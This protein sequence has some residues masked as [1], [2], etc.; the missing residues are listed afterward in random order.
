MSNS[1]HPV[2]DPLAIFG[3]TFDPVHY[4]H[5]RCAEE[6]RSQLGL[7]TVY[8]L[9]SGTPPHR[10]VPQ[11]TTQQRLEMLQLALGEFPALGIDGRETH[12]SG[13]SYMID[14]LM[15]LKA[16]Y[17]E[18]PI[19]LLLG[20]DV[21]NDLHTW[22]EWERLFDFAHIVVLTRPGST[23][24]YRQ[25]VTK[26][27][28]RRTCADAQTL[29][30]SQAGGVLYLGVTSVDVSATMIKSIIRLGRSPGSMM[31]QAV[32]EYINEKH[33]YLPV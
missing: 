14:T 19:L 2:G 15:E 21:A 18:R 28:D 3:G 6:A 29:L 33:L 4:G 32:W 12:R 9:P 23:A 31:P 30:E 24:E 20:Q 17:P 7:E 5:L 8:L 27:I 11:A 26:K 25:D 16:E 10:N 13:P 1:S 22:H